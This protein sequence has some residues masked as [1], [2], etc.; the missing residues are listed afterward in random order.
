MG[1]SGGLLWDD[2]D[3][4]DA[5]IISGIHAFLFTFLWA[6]AVPEVALFEPSVFLLA[7]AS[8]YLVTRLVWRRTIARRERVLPLKGGLIGLGTGA[9]IHVTIATL[10]AA[11]FGLRSAV[12]PLDV[13]PTFLVLG[14]LYTAGVPIFIT[15][16]LV[17]WLVGRRDPGGGAEADQRN[18]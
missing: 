14:L 15:G 13:W 7:P 5:G 2:P 9:C 16:I 8:A 4:S 3:A 11:I 18:D 6:G 12:G 1:S 17:G 10:T